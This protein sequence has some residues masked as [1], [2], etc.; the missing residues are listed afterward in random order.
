MRNIIFIISIFLGTTYF[1]SCSNEDDTLFNNSGNDNTNMKAGI[2]ST[3]IPMCTQGEVQTRGLDSVNGTFT[4]TYPYDTIY[5]H[6][7]DNNRNDVIA[8]PLKGTNY[9]G[10]TCRAI[11]LS[12]EVFDDGSYKVYCTD[13]PEE[14]ITLAA[15]EEV[16]FS[17]IKTPTWKATD[18]GHDTPFSGIYSG[19]D[20]F[21]NDSDNVNTEILKSELLY[22]A[23]SLI[24]LGNTPP[25]IIYMTRHSTG[26]RL[27]FMFTEVDNGGLEFP[28][29]MWNFLFQDAKPEYFYIKFYFGP[30]FCGEYD[31]L[32]NTTPA[33]DRGGFYASD[34]GIYRPFQYTRYTV[35]TG[36]DGS[37]GE[38]EYRTGFGYETS[39]RQYLLAPLNTTI[40]SNDFGF[41]V[42]I[43]YSD[44][45]NDATDPEFLSSDEGAKWFHY[46]VEGLTPTLNVVNFIIICMDY[47]DLLTQFKDEID[48]TNNAANRVSTR[49]TRGWFEN[50][51]PQEID[52]K[53]VDVKVITE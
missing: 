10:D 11:R 14:S 4:G 32:N 13:K 49:F 40:P 28:E 31:L 33:S 15:D 3:E 23:S 45:P 53:P 52:I 21:K 7:A 46:S 30:N 29:A 2:Y 37:T 38:D 44:D 25:Q 47:K 34:D 26:F 9:S 27:Q 1:M 6:P 36:G 42:Y 22:N 8:I 12:I 20:V 39:R 24:E 43:K 41:W 18:T 17:S 5:L 35:G 19:Y 51:A 48:A 50:R 16:Y